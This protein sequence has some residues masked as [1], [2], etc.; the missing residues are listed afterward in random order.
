MRSLDRKEMKSAHSLTWSNE[1]SDLS[2]RTL[3]FFHFGSAA[4]RLARAA[5]RGGY[6]KGRFSSS[7][8]VSS[9]STRHRR[10]PGNLSIS[11][12]PSVASRDLPFSL[13]LLFQPTA[14]ATLPARTLPPPAPPSRAGPPPSAGP[15]DSLSAAISLILGLVDRA[16][17]T[18]SCSLSLDDPVSDLRLDL[19]AE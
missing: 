12:R 11:S 7:S 17:A 14:P 6:V 13:P 4:R 5:G 1:A 16:G 2:T 10:R 8:T 15:S 19:E 3:N 18:R 9:R